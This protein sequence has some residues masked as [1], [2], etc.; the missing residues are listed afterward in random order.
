[1]L[2]SKALL[3]RIKTIGRR[4]DK[5]HEVFFEFPNLSGAASRGFRKQESVVKGKMK[6]RLTQMVSCAG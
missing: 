2:L 1:V 6:K 5:P 4:D 3:P